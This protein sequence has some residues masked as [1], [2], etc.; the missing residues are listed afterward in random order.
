M[1]FF[2]RFFGDDIFISYSRQDGALYAAGLADKMTEK[3]FSCFIDR[4]GV[5]PG[6]DLPRDLVKKIRRCSICV[7]VGTKMAAGSTFVGREMDIFKETK[8]VIL[9]IDFNNNIG[10]A[11]WYEKIPGL[12]AETEK[13]LSSLETGEPS[14]NVIAF[15]EKSFNYTRRNQ[16]M[17]RM[18]VLAVIMFILLIALGA[19]GFLI[20]NAEANKERELATV[21]R[22]RAA[23]ARQEAENA[24]RQAQ[25][26]KD[27]VA[28]AALQ[29]ENERKRANSEAARAKKQTKI[30]D[31][32]TREAMAATRTAEVAEN[33]K[34]EAEKVA[35]KQK[36]Q[37]QAN[38]AENYFNIAE[39][40][41]KS[42]PI[43]ALPW[44]EK[45]MELVPVT[46]ARFDLYRLSTLQKTRFSDYSV[47]NTG[48]AGQNIRSTYFSPDL[49]RVL[50]KTD[51]GLFL[52]DMKKGAKLPLPGALG[53]SGLEVYGAVLSDDGKRVCVLAGEKI[54]DRNDYNP[55]DL[56]AYVWETN[57]PEKFIK[58]HLPK[59]GIGN[60]NPHFLQGNR[61]L[62]VDSSTRSREKRNLIVWDTS[63][64][65]EVARF[66]SDVHLF[67]SPANESADEQ[68]IRSI[69]IYEFTQ[70][71][72]Q[73][74]K[75]N[76]IPLSKNEAVNKI[77]TFQN[78]EEGAIAQLRDISSGQVKE[79]PLEI[80]VDFIDFTGDA[81]KVI[82]L[83]HDSGKDK[84]FRIWDA[85]TGALIKTMPKSPFNDVL[86]VSRTGNKIIAMTP[87]SRTVLKLTD[88]AE[89][90]SE[91]V[92]YQ[93]D[94]GEE[95]AI[96]AYGGN[97]VLSYSARFADDDKYFTVITNEKTSRL[98]R[99]TGPKIDHSFLTVWEKDPDPDSY[100]PL[101]LLK[102]D[103]LDG[104]R[105][106]SR[107]GRSLAFVNH[108][109]SISIRRL[110]PAKAPRRGQ[111]NLALP[112]GES[113][114]YIYPSE[115]LK[116]IVTARRNYEIGGYEIKRWEVN[117]QQMK[118][119]EKWRQE[120]RSLSLGF[121]RNREGA[122]SPDN[123]YFIFAAGEG[124]MKGAEGFYI[125]DLEAETPPQKV[126]VREGSNIIDFVFNRNGTKIIGLMSVKGEAHAYEIHQWDTI[127]GK[128]NDSILPLKLR[129]P[130]DK[131]IS[132]NYGLAVHGEYF[133]GSPTIT[134]TTEDTISLASINGLQ[135][136]LRQFKFSDWNEAQ[137]TGE[138]IG[139]AESITFPGDNI[140]IR[141]NQ[142]LTVEVKKQG[143]RC[144][145][146]NGK[147][148][149]RLIVPNLRLDS[150]RLS[151]DG[152]YLA[153]I[154]STTSVWSTETG[155]LI[156]GRIG[157]GR[158]DAYVDFV[159]DG[160]SLI[161]IGSSG[162]ISTWLL[163][164]RNNAMPSWVH[165]LGSAI[166]GLEIDQGLNLVNIPQERL[167]KIRNDYFNRLREAA[168][169]GD[170]E[171]KYVLENLQ[172]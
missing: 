17:A 114:W 9:P 60:L 43:L 81:S 1:R 28:A 49:D 117:W 37:A 113:S 31:A 23:E 14:Q 136:E 57:D 139:Q 18:L 94:K 83:S 48:F 169:Q 42:N 97:D 46:D 51:Q 75:A 165:D 127:T 108:D 67:E 171:A 143:N 61:F 59:L 80:Y 115:D 152:K 100:F 38:L 103:N 159:A 25:E 65:Q 138:L 132:L 76:Y 72:R 131:N 164:N 170:E 95:R 88:L 77:I 107:S 47:I 24:S 150:A 134:A 145:L 122:L 98:D 85:N 137:L 112:E 146:F 116:T 155:S 166:T 120:N 52:W 86:A 154:S 124:F 130:D 7:I 168:R 82:T 54:L 161:T 44:L 21:E 12:A 19:G 89:K 106:F 148:G 50:F 30:A 99:E 32:K 156:T 41:A 15:I 126:K 10:K 8:R 79:L 84:I 87:P 64:R 93:V 104:M 162:K 91:L 36:Q 160:S 26:A 34:A 157:E 35:A 73:I 158:D 141:I 56:D 144:A 66:D 142:E 68:K 163:G 90:A 13:A 123:K 96:R 128:E 71:I 20:A 63:K 167:S 27:E 92:L 74:Y 140:S 102:I 118:A 119:I 172:P 4:L 110:I 135:S 149:R 62:I 40:T 55:V 105:T 33:N 2:S 78:L 133:L 29:T 109:G 147:T 16:Y 6:H 121:G 58:L 151:P 3:N 70:R 53:A 129:L 69:T 39:T 153:V 11:I 111:I 5:M 101:R 45:A 22:Q 125:F